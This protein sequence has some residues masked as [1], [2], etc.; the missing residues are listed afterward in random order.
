MSIEEG[1]PFPHGIL[2]F[3]CSILFVSPNVYIYIY[4]YLASGKE[5]APPNWGGTHDP[6]NA[7]LG[8][9]HRGQAV[10]SGVDSPGADPNIQAGVGIGILSDLTK[11]IYKYI[12]T[13]RDRERERQK[14]RER[15]RKAK[16]EKEC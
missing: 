12:H 7:D 8:N 9:L 5:A 4:I 14:K 1:H 11:D 13:E 3:V 10:E 15:E 6:N 16:Q 2:G